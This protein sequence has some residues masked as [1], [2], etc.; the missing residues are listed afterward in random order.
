MIT[1][2]QLD[3]MLA[4][5]GQE[6]LQVIENGL[7]AAR[8]DNIAV[9]PTD[10]PT[11]AT[12]GSGLDT[13]LQSLLLGA[14]HH[15]TAREETEL[16]GMPRHAVPEADPLVLAVRRWQ[17]TH[18]VPPFPPECLGQA[19]TLPAARPLSPRERYTARRRLDG[20]AER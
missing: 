16:R 18:P 8:Q 5:A 19:Y 11:T 10:P 15:H 9:T 4:T 2:D 12:A 7:A 1:E 20:R 17:Q 13:S 14:G 6:L 3:A